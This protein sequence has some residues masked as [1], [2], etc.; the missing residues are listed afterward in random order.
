MKSLEGWLRK[1]I[2]DKR[3]AKVCGYS[4]RSKLPPVRLDVIQGLLRVAN[5]YSGF[6]MGVVGAAH[7][8]RE[9]GLCKTNV[10]TQDCLRSHYCKTVRDFGY[11]INEIPCVFE[12]KE[13]TTGAFL[14]VMGCCG[15]TGWWWRG[16]GGGG[17]RGG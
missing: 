15:R 9:C 13:H 5:T 17:G 12:M 4:R 6:Q 8:F 7:W 14:G 1:N 3:T 11:T 2:T 10:E 16:G